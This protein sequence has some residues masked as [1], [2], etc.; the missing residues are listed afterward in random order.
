MS[1]EEIIKDLKNF[2]AMS[3][4]EENFTYYSEYKFCEEI[5][6]RVQGLLDLYEKEK[7]NSFSLSDKLNIEKEKNKELFEEYNKRVATIIKYEQEI[8]ENKAN[9]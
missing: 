2:C 3:K 1:E 4:K 8:K 6:E 9:E 7:L 5:A